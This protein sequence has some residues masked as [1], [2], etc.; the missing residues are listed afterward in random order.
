MDQR[1]RANDH[2]EVLL[3][4]MDGLQARLWTAL[5]AFVTRYDADEQVVDLKPTIEAQVRRPDGSVHFVSMPLLLDCPVQFPSGGRVTLTFPI[6]VGDE[7]LVVFASRCID[8]WWQSGSV[9]PPAEFRMHDLSDG[10]AIPGFRSLPK[11]LEN[12]STTT[13]QLRSE[14]GSTFVELDPDGQVVTVTAPG[15]IVLDG[16]V[17]ITG[18]T[19]ADQDVNVTGTITASVDVVGGGKHLKTHTHGGVTAGGA[20]TGAPN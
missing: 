13:A 5:P 16:N 15:G 1:E 14:D 2:D 18:T 17:H 12:V 9:Q 6:A 10:F 20:N 3:S 4:A 7:C 19:T 8:A 11:A